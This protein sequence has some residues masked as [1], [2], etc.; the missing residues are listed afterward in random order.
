MENTP[1]LV[2]VIIPNYNFARFFKQ[3]IESVLAQIFA[4]FEIIIVG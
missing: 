2:S 1:A 3:Y 4:K